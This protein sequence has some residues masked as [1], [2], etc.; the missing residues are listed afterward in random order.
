MK[1]LNL[2]FNISNS[3]QRL[4]N[5]ISPIIS[6]VEKMTAQIWEKI[7]GKRKPS[8]SENF[9]SYIKDRDVTVSNSQEV[10][11]SNLETKPSF[12]VDFDIIRREFDS[13]SL[14]KAIDN[15]ESAFFE[16]DFVSNSNWADSAVQEQESFTSRIIS[17]I[18][19]ASIIEDF[20]TLRI[21]E[22]L[23]KINPK[24]SEAEEKA[25]H[26]ALLE[27]QSHRDVLINLQKEKEEALH[28]RL[29]T[30]EEEFKERKRAISNLKALSEKSTDQFLAD[31]S[32]AR[33]QFGIQ[34]KKICKQAQKLIDERKNLVNSVAQESLQRLNQ[35]FKLQSFK[36][37]EEIHSKFLIKEEALERNLNEK[38]ES[39]QENLLKEKQM[40][41]DLSNQEIE[42][43]KSEMESYQERLVKNFQS[44]NSQQHHEEQPKTTSAEEDLLISPEA[45]QEME[46]VL[47]R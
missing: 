47:N 40:I 2:D 26:R 23:R 14:R 33:S 32:H 38:L 27:K 30:L 17:M 36:I 44:S 10:T 28:N 29:A 3:I 35:E 45:W 31:I 4:H 37:N 46:A 5:K 41:T 42:S 34:D 18:E 1:L 24:L 11:D 22:E 9:V 8:L 39:I 43:L 19:E 21:Q 15:H 25:A 12:E 6:R 13:L 7:N 20:F 16:D